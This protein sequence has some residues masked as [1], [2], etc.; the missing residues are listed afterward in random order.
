MLAK[1]PIKS[2]R[3]KFFLSHPVLKTQNIQHHRGLHELQGKI[4]HNVEIQK[5]YLVTAQTMSLKK[6]CEC[7]K[8]KTR[9]VKSIENIILIS[10]FP[11]L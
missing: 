11:T 5:S 6:T 1:K 10:H 3:K 4:S 9:N 7:R 2:L 8:G